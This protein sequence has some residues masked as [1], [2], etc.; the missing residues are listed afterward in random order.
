MT[1]E[2]FEFIAALVGRHAGYHIAPEKAYLVEKRL[3]PMIQ[4]HGPGG[5]AGLIEN[6]RRDPNGEVARALVVAM[7]NKE[8]FFFRDLHTFRALREEVIPGLQNQ[9][10]QARQLRIWSTGCATGQEPY[11]VAMVLAQMEVELTGWSVEIMA[12]DL[13]R[14]LIKKAASGLFTRFEMQRGLPVRMLLRHFGEVPDDQW[15]IDERMR[16]MVTFRES[17]LLQPADGFGV[18][19]IILC[20]N[21]LSSFGPEAQA[22]TLERLA[23]VLQ[24]GGMLMLGANESVTGPAGLFEMVDRSTGLYRR[25]S[26]PAGAN[27]IEAPAPAPDARRATA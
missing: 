2:E 17:N 15:Q 22:A 21:V 1:R 7:I 3:K 10:A 8:T 4:R 19:D 13:D 20:R 18:W 23:G 9:R 16:G 6:V 12:S 26:A 24:T 11:S 5:L 14:D 25:S 27:P